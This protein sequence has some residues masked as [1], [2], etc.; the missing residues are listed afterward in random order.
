M[1]Y[2][3]FDS[4]CEYLF[5]RRED[6]ISEN[7]KVREDGGEIWCFFKILFFLQWQSLAPSGAGLE[8]RDTEAGLALPNYMVLILCLEDKLKCE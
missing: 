3:P 6:A 8:Q 4:K 2:M 5:Q 1:G 7:R